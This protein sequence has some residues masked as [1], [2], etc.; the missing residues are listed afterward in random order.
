[1]PQTHEYKLIIGTI[2]HPLTDQLKQEG[3]QGWKPIL[4]STPLDGPN[5]SAQVYIILEHT[6]G[7]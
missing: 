6:L 1:M 7:A 2:K 4:M 3:R 5:G